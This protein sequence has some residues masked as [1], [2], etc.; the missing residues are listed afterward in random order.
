MVHVCANVCNTHAHTLPITHRLGLDTWELNL[1]NSPGAV[2]SE[3]VWE[4]IQEGRR[5]PSSSEAPASSSPRPLK[6]G[7][8]RFPRQQEAQWRQQDVPGVG[9]MWVE[10]EGRRAVG[11]RVPCPQ[12][13]PAGHLPGSRLGS[14][15][16]Q[17]CR[18]KPQ[19]TGRLLRPQD[20]DSG[21]VGGPWGSPL[22]STTPPSHR[23]LPDG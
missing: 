19:R 15:R 12:R 6:A 23:L 4:A 9:C 5:G 11:F 10:G 18:L 16:T 22:P 17:S 2:H 14:A 21:R 8:D 3:P 13:L 1:V 7:G 20:G